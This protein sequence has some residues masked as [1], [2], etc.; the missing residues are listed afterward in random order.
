[1]REFD[2]H[3]VFMDVSAIQPGRDFRKVIDESVA[4]CG[5]LLSVIGINW[6]DARNEAGERRLDDPSDF[7]RLETASALK[8]DIPVIPVL[9][10][11]A[12]MPQPRDLPEDVKDLAY[13]NAVELTHARWSGDLQFLSK[14]LHRLLDPVDETKPPAHDAVPPVKDDGKGAVAPSP[15]PGPKPTPVPLRRGPEPPPVPPDPDPTRRNVILAVLGLVILAG[16]SFA[17][18]SYFSQ[19]GVIVPDVRGSTRIA[20]AASLGHAGLSVGKT[21]VQADPAKEADSVIDQSASPG[22]KVD[23]GAKIDLVLSPA[24]VEIPNLVGQSRQSAEEALKQRQLVVGDVEKQP[25]E[26]AANNSVL[27]EF[28]PAGESAKPGT[29]VDLVIADAAAPPPDPTTVRVPTLVGR[30]LAQAGAQLEALGLSIGN[31]TVQAQSGVAP[32]TVLRQSPN[33]GQQV[34]RDSR[35]DLVIAGEPLP[36]QNGTYTVLNNSDISVKVI[37][38]GKYAYFE[39]VVLPAIYESIQVDVNQNGVADNRDTAYGQTNNGAPCTQYF[40]TAQSWTGCGGFKSAATVRVE[41]EGPRKKVTWVIPKSELS[42]R[43]DSVHFLVSTYE[44]GKGT[45]LYPSSTFAKTFVVNF[46]GQ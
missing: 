28:P 44:P 27:R 20:A 42:S 14:A 8:R 45:H 46:A 17:T 31:T 13:R 35:I 29:R 3:S 18:Y 43:G 36:L 34:Q 26:G 23:K 19:T 15:A 25:Q 6:V 41:D 16:V 32:G 39:M 12:K 4:T 5:V 21:T 2:D 9:V 37:D 22:A 11:G 40:L 10:R 24:L 38:K 33:S 7:V 30:T 1:V